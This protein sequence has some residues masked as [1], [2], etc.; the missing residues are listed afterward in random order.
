MF[1]DDVRN[2]VRPSTR[3]GQFMRVAHAIEKAQLGAH[4]FRE[5]LHPLPGVP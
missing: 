3:Q 1:D 2:Y 4:R 5:A